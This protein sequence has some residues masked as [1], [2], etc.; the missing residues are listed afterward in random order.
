MIAPRALR[1][2]LSSLAAISVGVGLLASVAPR[3]FYD[4]VPGVDGL[5]PYNQHLLTDVGGLY[6]GFAVLFVWAAA[7]LSRQ[8]VLAS[9]AAWGLIQLLHFIYHA[10]H[11]NGFGVAEASV[12]TAGLGATLALPIAAA[13]LVLRARPDPRLCR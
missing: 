1:F 2:V 3:A 10:T 4:E 8:L 9:C 11:L 12:Q 7:S 6:L 5:P 13:L